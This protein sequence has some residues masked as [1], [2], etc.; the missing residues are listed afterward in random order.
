VTP[1]Y[2]T[3]A[4]VALQRLG[5]L[6]WARRNT[7]RLRRLGAIEVD[8]RC[9]PLFVAL[10]VVWLASLVILVPAATAPNR[11][12]VLLFALLQ[13]ARIWVMAS[14]G[15]FWTTRI[16]TL[17]AAPLIK[18]GPYR[19]LRHPNYLIVA[20]EIAVLPLAFGAIGIAVACSALN[21][22]LTA[23]RVAIENRVLAARRGP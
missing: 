16:M 17:P 22:A 14:L 8:A 3:L 2:L 10:H 13:A 5:E 7:V 9:Y 19:W 23:R 4:L 21:L 20:A 12:L 1:L 15:R 6:A 11:A 18:T